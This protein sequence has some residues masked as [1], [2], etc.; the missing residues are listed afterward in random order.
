MKATPM[1][2]VTATY[3]CSIY[4]YEQGIRTLNV[5]VEV[6]AQTDK[7]YRIKLLAAAQNG[8]KPGDM[9]WVRKNSVIMPKEPID[10]TGEWWND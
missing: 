8:T 7:S 5:P 6:V 4:M 2:N 10:T 9:L 3:R 1:D